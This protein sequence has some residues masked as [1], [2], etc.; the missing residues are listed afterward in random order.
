MNRVQIARAASAISA[1]SALLAIVLLGAG[2]LEDEAHPSP[3]PPWAIEPA[4]D[5][6]GV[7]VLQSPLQTSPAPNHHHAAQADFAIAWPMPPTSQPAR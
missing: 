1:S 3:L 2:P 6:H 7:P 5:R 4:L